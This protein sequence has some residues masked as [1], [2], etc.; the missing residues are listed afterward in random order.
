MPDGGLP[1]GTIV[2]WNGAYA[3]GWEDA[4]GSLS[5]SASGDQIIAF[6]SAFE[7]PTPIF[8]LHYKSGSWD[9]TAS[10]ST[11]SGVPAGLEVGVTAVAL[12]HKDNYRFNGPALM[13][14]REAFLV[15]V[16]TPSNWVGSDVAATTE[17]PA[18]YEFGPSEHPSG[19]CLCV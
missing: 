11:T 14:S 3:F 2:T 10:S 17:L 8:A 6:S 5:L 1:R 18:H 19:M 4:P 13:A 16:C 7:D 12:G 15:A 9:A